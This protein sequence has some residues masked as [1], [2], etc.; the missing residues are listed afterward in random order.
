MST[1]DEARVANPCVNRYCHEHSQKF[2]LR[3]SGV[4][5]VAWCAAACYRL[6]RRFTFLCRAGHAGRSREPSKPDRRTPT[7]RP[8]H[9]HTTRERFI[10]EQAYPTSKVGPPEVRWGNFKEA[11]GV[12]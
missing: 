9:S 8:T 11:V 12:E 2:T 10:T 5:C 6:Y 3:P 7:A 1:V 4:E